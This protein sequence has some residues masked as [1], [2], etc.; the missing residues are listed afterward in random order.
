MGL[1]FEVE[2]AA[3]RSYLLPTELRERY[4]RGLVGAR[5]PVRAV[6]RT[7]W[8]TLADALALENRTPNPRALAAP[9]PRPSSP[10]PTRSRPSPRREI[11]RAI[12]PTPAATGAAQPAPPQATSPSWVRGGD[13][14]A[15]LGA[16]LLDGLIAVTVAWAT[17]QIVRSAPTWRIGAAVAAF[18][19]ASAAPLGLLGASVG[20]LVFGVRVADGEKSPGVTRAVAYEIGAY[21]GL[22]LERALGLELWRRTP[23]AAQ[24]R[25]ARAGAVLTAALAALLALVWVGVN[26]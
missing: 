19:A 7:E 10:P 15:L 2:S 13:A 4:R 9:Q 5:T 21:V 14:G 25:L 26:G 18:V 8:T 6:D 23:S 17:F 16:R 24:R 11:S 1:M 3:G 20:G 22:R 12:F